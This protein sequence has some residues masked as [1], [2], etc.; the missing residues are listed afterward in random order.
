[1]AMMTGY[2]IEL[3][4]K[5]KNVHGAKKTTSFHFSSKQLNKKAV[6]AA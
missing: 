1:V 6:L 5:K 2:R 4:T 3:I